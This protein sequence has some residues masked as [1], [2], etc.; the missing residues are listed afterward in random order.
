MGWWVGDC[1]DTTSEVG[2]NDAV[3]VRITMIREIFTSAIAVVKTVSGLIS[4]VITAVTSLLGT[5]KELGYDIPLPSWAWWAAAIASA[6]A[7][8]V[9]LMLQ[10]RRKAVENP[11][12]DLN[13]GDAFEL[14]LKRSRWARAKADR[15]QD[16]PK[17]W[18]ETHLDD[19]GKREERIAVA[20]THELHDLMRQGLLAV[21]ARK[22]GG[23]PMEKVAQERWSAIV[24]A[25][26]NMA[27]SQTPKNV[28]GWDRD[29]THGTHIVYMLAHFCRAELLHHFPLGLRERSINAS[30]GTQALDTVKT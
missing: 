9:H 19:A 25:F 15:W 3:R 7:L 29:E 17:G 27:L 13:A 6:Y 12:P 28:C 24:L 14:L 16:L 4:T 8:N 30:K 2:T 5:L 20:L 21:W 18:Y 23:G 1:E 11:R 22:D 26:D 10:L